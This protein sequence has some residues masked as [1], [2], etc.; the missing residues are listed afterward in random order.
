MAKHTE[1]EFEKEIVRQMVDSGDWREGSDDKYDANRCLYPEALHEFIRATQ[2]EEWEKLKSARGD[3]AAAS[4]ELQVS[5]EIT[6]RGTLDVLRNDLELFGC[7]FRLAYF[8]PSSG[9]NLD[10]VTKFKANVLTVVRQV[11][12]SVR[13]Q[14]SIDLVLFVNGI[15]IITSELKN[16]LTG[17]D[18]R[19]AVRQYRDDR[20]P[21]GEPFLQFGRCLAHFAVDPNVVQV[22]TK[23]EGPDTFFIPFN[24]GYDGGAGNPPVSVL[25]SGYST[26]YLWRDTWSRHTLLDIIQHFLMHEKAKG[27][28]KLGRMLGKL[29][30]PRWHQHR[31]VDRLVAQAESDGAGH[32]YLVQHSAG[33]GK[34]NT[35][36][37]LAHRLSQLQDAQD[38]RIFNAIIVV[39]DRK[40]LD[41]QLQHTVR[42][43]EKTRGLVETIDGTSKQL[44]EALEDGKQIIVTTLHKFPVILDSIGKLA[45]TRF[46]LLIDEAHSSQGGEMHQKMTKVL[47]ERGDVEDEMD[48]EDVIHL[49]MAAR[50][51]QDN[52]SVFAFTATPKS[53]T[54]ELFGTKDSDGRFVPFSLYS[55]RQAIEE[56]F[57]LDVLENYTTY[58]TYWKLKQG[59]E[60]DPEVESHKAK[61]VLRKFVLEHEKT[62]EDKVAIMMEHFT[63]HTMARID[64]RAKAMIVTSSRKNAVQYRLAVDKWIRNSEHD[65]KAL[66]AFTDTIT[67]DG[68]DYTESN[69]N[70]APDTQTA[71]TF[72]TDEHRILIVANKFL[73]GFDQPLLHTMYVDKRLAGVAAVQTLSRLNRVHPDKGETC[74]IDFAND[75]D[76]IQSSFQ[77][78]YETTLLESETDPNLIYK[79]R[80]EI[81]AEDLYS[82]QDAVDF[83][84]ILFDPKKGH[85]DLAGFLSPLV[86]RFVTHIEEDDKLVFR[87]RMREFVRG[88]AFLARVITF[89]D[90]K[91]EEF[92]H[93]CRHIVKLL[94]VEGTDLPMDIQDLVNLGS[95][96]ISRRFEGDIGLVRG[97][98]ELKPRGVGEAAVAADEEYDVLSAIIAA[99]NDRF[100]ADLTEADKVFLEAVVEDLSKDEGLQQALEVNPADTVKNVFNEKVA[101]LMFDRLSSNEKFVTKF[102]N[103]GDFQRELISML[104]SEV[105]H[106]VSISE[107]QKLLNLIEQGESTTLEFKATMRYNLHEKKNRD[108]NVQ[109]ACIKT[110]AAFLN[111]S[112]GG[113][114]LI[115]VRDD[116]K[117][118]GTR[119]DGFR[120]RGSED[121]DKAMLHLVNLI[122]RDIGPTFTPSCDMRAVASGGK[123]VIWVKVS[124]AMR[125]PAWTK[126]GDESV[127]YVRQ[128]PRTA[129]LDQAQAEEYIANHF[130]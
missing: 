83:C 95:L 89:Q 25:D 29:I 19:D 78:Y 121:S 110:I 2:F 59:A 40:V 126:K 60:E 128:G 72:D 39:T 70:G 31:S 52:I 76:T 104:F 34:S 111:S 53:K 109:H 82:E 17:Q 114:L 48:Y 42:L 63:G 88:Y 56:K 115:G 11:H 103:D 81:L 45:G 118:M 41:A 87:R 71:A 68:M 80:R 30:F 46:A 93:F 14:N 102:A 3:Q 119:I 54:L 33:S 37:W 4:L 112:Y 28:R 12:Y 16:P 122:N 79:L 6:Q 125:A 64:G 98:S 65:F 21:K 123:T 124:P 23:L 20:S 129:A 7:R 73:T 75:A 120:D 35:I 86:E 92:Y 107:E 26:Q 5:Q 127:F 18:F 91:L 84:K 108:K 1:Y 117:V 99:L 101:E 94:P 38:E 85:A 97:D 74:V 66:V 100:G 36:A 130:D 47:T 51:K 27:R 10:L 116:R 9:R 15:P 55:M 58:A 50:G 77:D 43:Y 90:Q 113:S 44:R 69:M 61:S 24:R 22:S 32:N 106:N 49:E 57:I 67:I 96:R 13:N 105:Q 62:V 8:P